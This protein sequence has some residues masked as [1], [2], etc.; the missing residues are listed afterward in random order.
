MSLL[1]YSRSVIPAE[2]QGQQRGE[3]GRG[4]MA[5]P[6]APVQPVL[7]GFPSSLRWLATHVGGGDCAA[8]RNVF[9]SWGVAWALPKS[10]HSLG[11]IRNKLPCPLR[12]HPATRLCRD[13]CSVLLPLGRELSASEAQTGLGLAE[14][15]GLL[16]CNW[17]D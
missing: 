10:C 15:D 2:R 7:C 8:Q 14:L 12:L 4:K 6:T 9:S 13:P 16:V 11:L 1:C 17:D 3:I 5:P